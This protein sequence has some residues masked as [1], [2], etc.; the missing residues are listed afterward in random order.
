M[1]DLIGAG[2]I[3]DQEPWIYKN[4]QI[5]FQTAL[6]DLESTLKG[7]KVSRL[8]LLHVERDLPVDQTVARYYQKMCNDFLTS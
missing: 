3:N 6:P 7:L 8:W 5:S 2:G 1:I 4:Q